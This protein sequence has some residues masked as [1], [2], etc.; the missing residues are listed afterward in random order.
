MVRLRQQLCTAAASRSTQREMKLQQCAKI[1]DLRQA[2]L[3]AG[4]CSLNAQSAALGLSRSTSWIVLKGGHKSSGLTGSIV[5][6]MLESPQLPAAARL[7]IEQ[8]VAQKMA[9]AYGHD[10]KQIERFWQRAFGEREQRL[11][12]LQTE[13]GV[14]D[15]TGC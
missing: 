5:R 15:R 9:G 1:A 10:Q 6:R 4:C 3:S 7:V 8:Y 2:L 14:R 11:E 13:R 12:W